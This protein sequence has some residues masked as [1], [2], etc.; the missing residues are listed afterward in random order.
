MTL[1][2]NF[3]LKRGVGLF[4]GVGLISGDYGNVVSNNYVPTKYHHLGIG[5]C[6]GAGGV[7]VLGRLLRHFHDHVPVLFLPVTRRPVAVVLREGVRERKG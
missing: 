6:D 5:E 2:N 7:E 3:L 4:S 1:Y